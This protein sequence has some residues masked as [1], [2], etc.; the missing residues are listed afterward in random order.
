MVG[1]TAVVFIIYTVHRLTAYLQLFLRSFKQVGKGAAFIL[2]ETS[3]AGF[4]AVLSLAAVYNN[5]TFAAAV[6]GIVQTACYIAI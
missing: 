4:T 5:L 1:G 3:A 6:I 2:I